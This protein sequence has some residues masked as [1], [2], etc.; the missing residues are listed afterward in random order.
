MVNILQK[1]ESENIYI[2]VSE[3]D[4]YALSFFQNNIASSFKFFDAILILTNLT[5][6]K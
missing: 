6:I 3:S 5:D 4:I 2:L 1:P